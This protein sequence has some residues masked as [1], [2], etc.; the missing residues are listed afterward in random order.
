MGDWKPY[1]CISRALLEGKVLDKQQSIL[2]NFTYV[3]FI[4]RKHY[5]V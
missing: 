2:N 5:Y 1:I 4:T 3:K